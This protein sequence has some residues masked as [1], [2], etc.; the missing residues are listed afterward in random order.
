MTKAALGSDDDDGCCDTT[1]SARRHF[2]IESI[3]HQSEHYL[4]NTGGIY[5]MDVTTGRFIV[6]VQTGNVIV[7][8]CVLQ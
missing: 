4:R 1:S 8:L 3:S 5:W 7:C 2:L 6:N